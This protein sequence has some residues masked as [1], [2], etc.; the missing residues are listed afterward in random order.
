MDQP[1][2][3]EALVWTS[4]EIRK[5]ESEKGHARLVIDIVDGKCKH[6]ES[7]KKILFKQ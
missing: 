1:E 4:E 5:Y 3:K 7:T 6:A 2:N